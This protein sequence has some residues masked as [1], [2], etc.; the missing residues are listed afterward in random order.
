MKK[1][2]RPLLFCVPGILLVSV[3][4]LFGTNRMVGASADDISKADTV[5][6]VFTAIVFGAGVFEGGQPSPMLA[7]RVSTGIDLYKRGKV[8]KLLMT[9][10]K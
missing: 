3:L 8:K 1:S 10:D 4:V 7:D 6:P 5:K 2:L 9:G